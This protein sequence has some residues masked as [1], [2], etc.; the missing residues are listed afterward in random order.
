MAESYL[1]TIKFAADNSTTKQTEKKLNSVFDRVTKRFKNGIGKIGD[2]FKRMFTIGGAA[3]GLTLLMTRLL[4]PLAELNDRINTTLSRAR[5][6][7]ARAQGYG[8]DVKT[9]AALE[10]YANTAGIS[11]ETFNMMMS[12][13]QTGVAAA[14]S[15]EKNALRN[16][17]K[18]TDIGKVIYNLMNSLSEETDLNRRTNIVN[19]IFGSRGAAQLTPLITGGF[20]GLGDY[21]KG[22]DFNKYEEA[23]NK[24]AT[25]E[26]QQSQLAFIRDINDMIKKSTLI[27]EET[28][29]QQDENAQKRLD[30]E[31]SQITAYQTI[32][33][34]DTQLLKIETT[35]LTI[36]DK[37]GLLTKPL[38]GLGMLA[39]TAKDAIE[40]PKSHLAVIAR[41]IRDYGLPGGFVASKATDF[42]KGKFG[43]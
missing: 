8:T 37:I 25:L 12:R 6:I 21:V 24:L 22:L 35:L 1:I 3:A 39:D 7:R 9:Y 10:G 13:V 18:E 43:K 11:P 2:Q 23:I 31:N 14:A 4:A 26:T 27:T 29:K 20:K 33:N 38:E 28:V 17:S 15:G 42:V 32:A 19:N 34:L 41:G 36:V 40:D 5:D 16:Y 30:F